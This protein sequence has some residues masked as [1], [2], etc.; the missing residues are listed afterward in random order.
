[1]ATVVGTTVDD[2]RFSEL[3]A[4]RF[5]R[6]FSP[7][8]SGILAWSGAR[9]R[10]PA[11]VVDFH[12]W[13]D[14]RSDSAAIGALTR[15]L[16]TMPKHLLEEPP[17]LPE[18]RPYDPDGYSEGMPESDGFSFL[19]TWCHEGERNMIEQGIPA[20]EW[21]R[22]HR[23]AYRTIR[24][25]PNGRRVGYMSIATLTWLNGA[26]A[27]KGHRDPFAWWSGVGDFAA[28]DCYAASGTR[29]PLP[30]DLF[31]L[32]DSLAAGTGRRAFVPE[33]GSVRQGRPAE[34]GI[35]RARWI[36]Q[37][38]SY[39]RARDYAGVAWWDHFGANGRDFRLTD[40]WSRQAW[41][42]QLTFLR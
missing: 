30:E 7:P 8:G 12:S 23:L 21:R 42:N 26:G 6:T 22:R 10:V 2:S 1:M 32:L 14:W 28:M 37:V 15:L 25:H 5:C 16:D 33:L 13:K 11:G 34:P 4:A 9:R 29:Y 40:A 35:E 20:H 19:L 31:Q 3:S 36:G 41:D 24:E 18:L 38:M 27:D 39:A 17:L